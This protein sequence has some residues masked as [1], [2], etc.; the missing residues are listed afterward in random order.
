[1]AAS[2]QGYPPV[3]H[4]WVKS[5]PFRFGILPVNPHHKLTPKALRRIIPYAKTKKELGYPKLRYSI[6]RHIACTKLQLPEEMAWMFY[7]I[8]H[9]LTKMRPEDRIQWD[10]EFA[11]HTWTYRDQLKGLAV[12]DTMKFVILLYIQLINRTNVRSSSVSSLSTE[13]W[14]TQ[15]RNAEWAEG[16][17]L[18]RDRKLVDEQRFLQFIAA[19]LEEIL[20]I[21]SMGTEQHVAG[22]IMVPAEAV[23]ALGFVIEGSLDDGKGLSPLLEVV[24]LHGSPCGF[25]TAHRAFQLKPLAS[26]LRTKLGTNPFGISSCLVSGRRLSWPTMRKDKQAKHNLRSGRIA[27][28]D[29]YAPKGKKV[30]IMSHISSQVIC[31]S[32]RS[33]RGFQVQLYRCQDSFVYLLAP[34]K[35]VTVYK[36]NN[37]TFVLGTVASCIYVSFCQNVTVVSATRRIWINNTTGSKFYLLTPTQPVL[38]G[39]KNDSLTLAPFSTSYPLLEDQMTEVGLCSVPNFWNSPICISSLGSVEDQHCWQTMPPED[40]FMLNIPFDMEKPVTTDIPLGLP[41]AYKEVFHKREQLMEN[42]HRAVNEANLNSEQQTQLQELVQARFQSWLI[43][44]GLQHE[45]DLLANLMKDRTA[46]ATTTSAKV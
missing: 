26:W 18:H 28:N 40:F 15:P 24:N 35:F 37:C 20:E 4:V 43:R 44:T 32:H 27:T 8:Y 39:N 9:S 12:V 2:Y 22:C 46:T 38:A 36:C 25:S 29:H 10:T 13:E 34:L 23:A 31:R 6:W 11:K 7:C 3:A 5:E 1:M 42:W 16:R 33:L 21:L 17:N 41:P 19:H 30:I 45:L 14:P